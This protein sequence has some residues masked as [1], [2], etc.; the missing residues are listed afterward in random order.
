MT[1]ARKHQ[2]LLQDTA[3]TKQRFKRY[4]DGK[5]WVVMGITTVT[6]GLAGLGVTAQAAT[7]DNAATQTTVISKTGDAE[8]DTP[9]TNSQT[10]L[11]NAPAATIS[12]QTPITEATP[13][14]NTAQTTQATTQTPESVPVSDATPTTET[15]SATTETADSST[16]TTDSTSSQI[17]NVGDVDDATYNDI[18]TAA[19]EAYQTTGTP[20]VVTRIAAATAVTPQTGTYGTATWDLAEDGALTIHAGTMTDKAPC[21]LTPIRLPQL[22]PKPEWLPIAQPI[23]ITTTFIYLAIYQTSRRST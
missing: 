13:V 17:T 10:T 21:Y 12:E 2:R 16:I 19:A 22:P 18:K 15:A 7:G 20:Q 5:I 6:L 8:N 4:K 11:I 23:M 14:A 3:T 9:L 1:M